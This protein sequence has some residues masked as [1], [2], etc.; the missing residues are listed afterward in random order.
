[1]LL[2]I[3]QVLREYLRRWRMMLALSL[4]LRSELVRLL[5]LLRR[6]VEDGLAVVAGVL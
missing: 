1:L 3:A 5:A 4:V 2:R 6:L